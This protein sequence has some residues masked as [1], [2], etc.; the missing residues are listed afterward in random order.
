MRCCLD[1]GGCC[2]DGGGC[3]LDSVGCCLDSGGCCLDAVQCCY[4]S[5]CAALPVLGAVLKDV[6][7]PLL[8]SLLNYMQCL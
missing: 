7:E 2:L 5:V 3:C 4:K 1:R 8:V 6:C